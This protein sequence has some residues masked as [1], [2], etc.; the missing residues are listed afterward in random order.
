[1][2]DQGPVPPS[3]QEAASWALADL[4]GIWKVTSKRGKA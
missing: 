3:P 1:M 4:S 2:G